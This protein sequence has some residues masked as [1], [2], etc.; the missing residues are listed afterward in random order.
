MKVIYAFCDCRI[1]EAG[2]QIVELLR[3]AASSRLE[4][5]QL[6]KK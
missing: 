3:L 6:Q 1:D 5:F 2:L 4:Q